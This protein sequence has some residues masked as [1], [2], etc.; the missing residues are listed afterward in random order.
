VA[1]G[2]LH[3]RV[4]A[5]RISRIAVVYDPT[6]HVG[7]WLVDFQA[8]IRIVVADIGAEDKAIPTARAE[9]ELRHVERTEYATANAGVAK[10]VVG[11]RVHNG[12]VVPVPS[13][14]STHPLC[15]LNA[16]AER[17]LSV[18]KISMIE[19]AQ[20]ENGGILVSNVRSI[21]RENSAR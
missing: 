3:C 7:P 8:L 14:L 9:R 1:D 12:L 5:L 21:V 13:Y 4:K 16:D 6:Q 17:L 11:R 2:D 18:R 19:D 20:K 10:K 15:S